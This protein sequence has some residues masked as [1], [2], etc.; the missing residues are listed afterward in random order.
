MKL[1]EYLNYERE[2]VVRGAV[3]LQLGGWVNA[4]IGIS[5]AIDEAMIVKRE[6]VGKN[7]TTLGIMGN[8]DVKIKP[9]K[10]WPEPCNVPT[11]NYGSSKYG[12]TLSMT[13]DELKVSLGMGVK[14]NWDTK[15]GANETQ[16]ETKISISTGWEKGTSKDVIIDGHKVGETGIGAEA[17]IDAFVTFKNGHVTDM[18]VEG[19][20]KISGEAGVKSGNSKVDNY[21]PKGNVELSASASW[22]VQTGPKGSVDVPTFSTSNVPTGK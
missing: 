21:L 7:L 3:V 6:C 12:A 22:T 17:N 8:G 14:I 1:N 20:A 13:C 11:G 2:T 15:F 18:G 19:T 16:D 10:T 4:C 5:N 9:L